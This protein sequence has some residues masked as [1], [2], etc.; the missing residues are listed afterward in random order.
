MGNSMDLEFNIQGCDLY[1]SWRGLK[2]LHSG[3]SVVCWG[4]P[5]GQILIHF[6]VLG[7]IS[8]IIGWPLEG[9]FFQFWKMTFQYISSPISWDSNCFYLSVFLSSYLATKHCS[10]LEG[11]HIKNMHT[12][13]M[14]VQLIKITKVYRGVKQWESVCNFFERH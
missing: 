4:C 13:R 14:R 11:I 2:M 12:H 9:I 8:L 3:T 1:K 6:T 7:K 5:W 10:F